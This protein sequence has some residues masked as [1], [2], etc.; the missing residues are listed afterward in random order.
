MKRMKIVVIILLVFIHS[1]PVLSQTDSLSR[2]YNIA[3]F[4]PLFLDSAFDA[5]E[6]YRYGKNFP[7]F[8]NAGLEFYEGVQ[9]AIDSLQREGAMLDVHVFDT[10]SGSPKFDAV[11]K[12]D[13]LNDMDLIIGHVTATEARLLADS[14]A[15]KNIPFINVNFFAKRINRICNEMSGCPIL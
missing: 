13:S 8:F 12:S 10:K 11:I 1:I 2:R 3:V 6:S 5:T 15:K 14:A 4:T 9:L 7:R